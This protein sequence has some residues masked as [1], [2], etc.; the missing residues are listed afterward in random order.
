MDLKK[1][2]PQEISKLPNQPGV[3]K[4]FDLSG[5]IIYIG[6]AKDL[7]KRVSS[8]FTK[9]ANIN[10][11]T[12]KLVSEVKM[13]EI[14]IVNSE[15]DAL[16]LENSLIKEYQPKYNI[17]LKDDKSFPSIL[18]T[19]DRFP[20]IYS[21]RQID[22][23]KGEYFGP[24][25][26]VKAMNSVLDLI[27]KLYKIRTCNLALTKKN[28]TEKKF[29]ICLEYHLGNCLGPCEGLQKED[30]YL[31]E[32]EQSKNI[33][34][35][36]IQVVKSYFTEKMNESAVNLAFEEAQKFKEKLDLL[37]KFQIR[38]L[39]VNQR[40]TDTDVFTILT[41]EDTAFVNYMR[42]KHGSINLSE[43]VEI[44]RKLDETEE[45]LLIYAIINL[46]EK[47]SSP[48]KEIFTNLNVETWDNE[49]IITQPKIGDK[50]K[51]VDLS[52]KNLLFYKKEKISRATPKESSQERVLKQLKEDLRL[53]EIPTHI[54]CFDNSN[55]SGT[56]PVASMVC[57][58]NAKPSKK[59]YRHFKIKTVVG[60]DDFGS[61]KEIVFRRYSRLKNEGLPFPKLI[62]IDG[63]KGQLNAALESL[64]ELELYGQIPIIGI[65][66][67]LEELYF[68]GDQIPIHINKKSESLKLLQFLRDEAHRFAITFHRD[69]RS[70]GSLVSELDHLK[71]IG[72]VSKEKLLRRFKTI[73][74]IKQA[75]ITDLATEIGLSRAQKLKDQFKK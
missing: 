45:E 42:I 26:S 25:T 72:K 2:S 41:E 4:Y 63:G 20:K 47:F 55:I 66:K 74:A 30:N 75:S 14:V 44:K 32:I 17:L 39:I 36:K 12:L 71:G 28:V 67:R 34:K 49:T 73:K 70:K 23:S 46:K 43:T 5:T 58:K 53:T 68:P 48:N 52:I 69:L 27:R 19:K 62:V 10:R 8:Y 51:L 7:K 50:K 57:F 13:L 61:M 40:I 18:I 24:Y 29:K 35:G 56:N 60:P 1:F 16:L 3:Y 37:D 15:F 65:A 9:S 31:E 64:K 21:T 33:L 54:E 38:S 59:D 6:K 11:K 22:K